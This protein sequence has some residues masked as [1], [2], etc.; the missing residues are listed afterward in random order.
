MRRR[1]NSVWSNLE[2]L[3]QFNI[4][5]GI[6]LDGNPNRSQNN[7]TNP[8]AP[9][10]TRNFDINEKTLAGYAQLKFDFQLGLP[11]D[12]AAR[13]SRR[14]DQRPDQ[15]FPSRSLADRP[16]VYD[17]IELSNSYTNWLPNLNVNV[18]FT[19]QLKLRLAA[20]KT[21]TRPLFEQLN[22]GLALGHRRCTDPRNPV[23]IIHGAAAAIRS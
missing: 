10:E 7:D 2:A 23:C 5:N 18:H 11:V 15:R 17:P 19:D 13:C 21:L 9:V 16:F 12:G 20:T 8:P 1:F 22:P 14:A 6:P 4:N 3:R